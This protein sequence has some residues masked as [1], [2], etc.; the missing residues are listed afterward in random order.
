LIV[1]TTYS[2]SV[3]LARGF[4]RLF[5]INAHFCFSWDE[6]VSEGM[7]GWKGKSLRMLFV[8][9]LGALV[10]TIYGNKGIMSSLALSL[11]LKRRL[12]KINVGRL[13]LELWGKALASL[14][15]VM[16]MFFFDII[17]V[18]LLVF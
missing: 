5:W 2:L 11:A 17:G 15:L 13:V 7:I 18:F 12:C 10:F 16:L 1:Q 14:K 8:S 3:N 9:W 6:L 4:G